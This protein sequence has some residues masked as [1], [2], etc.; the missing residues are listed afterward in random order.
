LF[1]GGVGGLFTQG[2]T[3]IGNAEVDLQ[4]NDLYN[5]GR[6]AST[7]LVNI[8]G[9]S[10]SNEDG[11]LIQGDLGVA[12]KVSAASLGTDSAIES[13]YGAVDLAVNSSLVSQGAIRTNQNIV[14]QINGAFTNQGDIVAGSDVAILAAGVIRN[15]QKMWQPIARRVPANRKNDT[16]VSFSLLA[17][18]DE[19]G[20]GFGLPSETLQHTGHPHPVLS[21]S[22]S[23]SS[24]RL[25]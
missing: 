25:S 18:R 15:Q 5:T 21:S 6:I 19:A 23:E 4:A 10:L 2:G 12:I 7:G 3:L 13:Y 24:D 14:L 17:V 1:S 22:T 9:W 20:I 16:G 8:A 11:G